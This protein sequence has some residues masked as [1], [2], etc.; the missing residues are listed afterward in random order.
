[1]GSS[2]LKEALDGVA[3]DGAWKLLHLRG[4]E[5]VADGLTKPLAGQAFFKFVDDLGFAGSRA[6]GSKKEPTDHAAGGGGTMQRLDR[7]V[8]GSIASIN[9]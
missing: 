6:D 1:M 8:L 4:T 2:F 3:S 5:L 9:S 7:W